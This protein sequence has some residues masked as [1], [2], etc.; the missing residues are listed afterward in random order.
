MIRVVAETLRKLDG[1][2]GVTGMLGPG[3]LKKTLSIQ[4]ALDSSL[5]IVCCFLSTALT[6][7][8]RLYI[9]HTYILMKNK[10]ESSKFLLHFDKLLKEEYIR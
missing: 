5:N 6:H 2:G 1:P 7:L 3:I 8:S 4:M 9:A 10:N